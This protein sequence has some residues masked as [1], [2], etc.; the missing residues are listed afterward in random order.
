[1]TEPSDLI[2]VIDT[3]EQKPYRFPG[4]VTKALAAGDYSVLGLECR[5]AVE[6][7]EKADAY[8]SLGRGRERFE[9][10][11]QRLSTYD[12]AAI[13][14]EAALSDFLRP[15]GFSRMSPKAAVNTLVSWSI[16]YGVHVYFADSRRLGQAL[17][18]RI[19]EKYRKHRGG[20]P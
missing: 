17:T 8:N 5:V 10:E 19:L 7:K 2:V 4:A 20:L 11:L 18:L 16:R 15:P 3:R 13:V 14:I 6:R 1:M 9:R 12:Y